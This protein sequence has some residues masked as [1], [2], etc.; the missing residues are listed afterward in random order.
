MEWDRYKKSIGDK[1]IVDKFIDDTV[2]IYGSTKIFSVYEEIDGNN[3]FI[4]LKTKDAKIS[5][6]F[7]DY[8]KESVP[9]PDPTTH[10][11]T[12]IFKH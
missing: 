4:Y 8:F 11:E 7:I 6:R 9:V 3:L 2:S 10:I 5:R 1:E 12:L